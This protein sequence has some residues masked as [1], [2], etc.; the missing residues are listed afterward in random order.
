MADRVQA[1]G[2]HLTD[3]A[4]VVNWNGAAAWRFRE[5]MRD[6]DREFRRCVEILDV[7][8]DRVQALVDSMEHPR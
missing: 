2:R 3:E 7:A 4:E 6:R 5:H 8:R 1:S